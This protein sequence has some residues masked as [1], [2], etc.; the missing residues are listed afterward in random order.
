MN[1]NT[2]FVFSRFGKNRSSINSWGNFRFSLEQIEN[3]YRKFE[4]TQADWPEIGWKWVPTSSKTFWRHVNRDSTK[5]KNLRSNESPKLLNFTIPVDYWVFTLVPR[6]T[7]RKKLE[8]TDSGIPLKIRT[9]KTS[10]NIWS[11]F[12]LVFKEILFTA[13]CSWVGSREE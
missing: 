6:R 10:D 8:T 7:W 2:V 11:C 13:T 9:Q 4:C 12:S 1:F 3:P 5:S